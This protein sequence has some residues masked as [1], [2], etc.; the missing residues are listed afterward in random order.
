MKARGKIQ[1]NA[2]EVLAEFDVPSNL[3]EIPLNR[4]IDF[5]TE[6]GNATPDNYIQQHAKAVSAFYG[7][8][9]YTVFSAIYSNEDTQDESA[10][11]FELNTVIQLHGYAAQMIDKH[12]S[13][14]IK[15]PAVS[16]N[17]PYFDFLGERYNI[18]VIV[19]RVLASG[20]HDVLPNLSVIEAIE[21]SEA[22]RVFEATVEND[23]DGSATFAKYLKLLAVLCR[24]DGEQLPVDDAQRELFILERSN[25][26]GGQNGEVIS[27]GIALDIDFFLTAFSGRLKNVQPVSTFLYLRSLTIA[28]LVTLR[29]QPV[30]KPAQ[31]TTANKYLNGSGGAHLSRRS[32][33]RDSLR[34]D[35]KA[36]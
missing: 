26:F 21:A 3:Y 10:A 22:N 28:A 14:A 12:L 33:K 4:Y 2:G 13:E 11:D 32:L 9:L 1:N 35:K 20:L 34:R 17:N 15:S 29:R 18:P 27:A 19:T 6:V 16:V 8:D 5:L 36:K 30:R 25:I 7:V 31:K 23:S 24:K